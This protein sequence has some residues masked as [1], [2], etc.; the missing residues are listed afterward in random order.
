MALLTDDLEILWEPTIWSTLEYSN[1]KV[2]RRHPIWVLEACRADHLLAFGGAA[3]E[4]G[5]I[6]CFIR[7]GVIAWSRLFW[8]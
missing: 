8:T 7:L 2:S 3:D 5:G 4:E 6:R 1:P